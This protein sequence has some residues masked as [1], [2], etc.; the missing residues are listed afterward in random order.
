MLAK[1]GL[2]PSS[3]GVP[4]VVAVDEEEAKREK[5][6]RVRKQKKRPAKADKDSREGLIV[7]EAVMALRVIVHEDPLENEE[8]RMR[9]LV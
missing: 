2:S 7:A 3:S 5:A 8:V 9:L 1:T 6:S 4:E